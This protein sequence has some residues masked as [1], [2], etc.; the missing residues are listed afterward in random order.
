MNQANAT[1][2]TLLSELQEVRNAL[3]FLPETDA[4]V[5]RLG[6]LMTRVASLT[7]P[8]ARFKNVDFHDGWLVGATEGWAQAMAGVQQQLT[9]LRLERD[10]ARTQSEGVLSVLV[11]IH[12]LTLPEP[13]KVNG[14]TYAFT[15]P[16]ACTWLHELSG[17]IRAIPDR[18]EA[19]AGL[20]LPASAVQIEAYSLSDGT[21]IEN[22][23]PPNGSQQRWA[24]RRNNDCMS[25]DLQ[26]SYEPLPSSRTQ[27]WLAQHRF[28]SAQAA[29]AAALAA[30][31]AQRQ[32]DA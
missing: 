25:L 30:T 1:A 12:N 13:V 18:L 10:L 14:K 5:D 6:R 17:R 2:P 7:S 21:R 31:Q 29:I 23:N 24:V 16:E 27:E 15:P 9:S 20:S 32:G 4:A 19:A 11:G 8:P 28:P 26:W 22:T 3:G